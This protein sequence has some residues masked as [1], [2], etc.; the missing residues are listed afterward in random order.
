MPTATSVPAVQRFENE[1]FFHLKAHPAM[2]LPD[3]LAGILL[4]ERFVRACAKSCTV[5]HIKKYLL[6]RALVEL[7]TK[8]DLQTS[9]NAAQIVRQTIDEISIF[10][11]VK[12]G[13]VPLNVYGSMNI[14]ALHSKFRHL[15]LTYPLEFYYYF[16]E[17]DDLRLEGLIDPPSPLKI[18]GLHFN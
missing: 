7:F 14:V 9:R 16:H 3:N 5:T 12:D 2:S 13:L 6:M 15:Q 10:L 8:G 17:A 18:S 11:R 4:K 1:V